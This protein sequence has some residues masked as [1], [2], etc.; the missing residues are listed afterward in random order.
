[1]DVLINAENYCRLRKGTRRTRIVFWKKVPVRKPR[2][3]QWA[4][5]SLPYTYPG[6]V[7]KRMEIHLS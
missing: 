5:A 4:Q 7:M 2:L 1:L 6:I 3:R